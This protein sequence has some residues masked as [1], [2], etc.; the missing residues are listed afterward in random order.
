MGWCLGALCEPSLH[1]D[2]SAIWVGGIP[3]Q[4]PGRPPQREQP[5]S[6]RFPCGLH[7]CSGRRHVDLKP[8]NLS[9]TNQNIPDA[10]TDNLTQHSHGQSLGN[11]PSPSGLV[12]TLQPYTGGESTNRRANTGT[13]T[14]SQRRNISRMIKDRKIKNILRTEDLFKEQDFPSYYVLT[15]PGTNVHTELNVIA[16]DTE[17]RQKIGNPKK[18][19]KLNK[20]SLRI[21]KTRV[22]YRRPITET[23]ATLL[24]VV[25][26]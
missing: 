3:L 20:N 25:W 10:S 18:I 11:S 14:N 9:K 12:Q 19:S 22:N 23:V 2:T 7:G 17:I 26:S 4:G 24:Y 6:I 8:P 13:R 15:F 21:K 1:P 5:S 16:V